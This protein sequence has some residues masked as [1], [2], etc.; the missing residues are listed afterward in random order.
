MKLR[1]SIAVCDQDWLKWDDYVKA[2]PYTPLS[3]SQHARKILL[4]FS[5]RINS[6]LVQKVIESPGLGLRK[7]WYYKLSPATHGHYVTPTPDG[8]WW[9]DIA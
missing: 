9:L 8:T 1:D 6:Q 5:I 4:E 2:S 7:L 3:K